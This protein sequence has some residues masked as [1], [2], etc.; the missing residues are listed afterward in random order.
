[1]SAQVGTLRALYTADGAFPV[2]AVGENGLPNVAL[3]VFADDLRPDPVRQQRA[4]L[5]ARGRTR[6]ARRGGARAMPRF[7]HRGLRSSMHAAFLIEDRL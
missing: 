2:H 3:G 6:C 7:Y 5:R 1:M 4:W